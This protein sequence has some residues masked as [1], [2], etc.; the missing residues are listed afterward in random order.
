M[1][2]INFITQVSSSPAIPG[3][4]LSPH[5]LPLGL[6]I[7]RSGLNYIPSVQS[8]LF[9]ASTIPLGQAHEYPATATELSRQR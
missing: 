9:S 6:F 4:P 2:I 8:T 5:S 1:E 7:S 3:P